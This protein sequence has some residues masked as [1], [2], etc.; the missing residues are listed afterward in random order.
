M[1]FDVTPAP[2]RRRGPRIPA[3]VV[4]AVGIGVVAVAVVT[5]NPSQPAT[6]PESTM[7][8]GAVARATATSLASASPTGPTTSSA[9]FPS[10]RARRL[11]A[12]LACHAVSDAT[13]DAVATASLAILPADAPRVVG[14]DAWASILCGDSL[15]CPTQV[16]AASEPLGSAIISFAGGGPQAWVNV[17]DPSTSAAGEGT[18]PGPIAWIVRWQP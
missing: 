5:A 1:A 16:L 3:I 9:P 18:A 6:G 4:L 10:M 17:V 8:A 13:C 7:S 12:N 11:P 2:V 14:I 15:D